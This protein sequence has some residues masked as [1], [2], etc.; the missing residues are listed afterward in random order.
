MFKHIKKPVDLIETTGFLFSILFR[1]VP[2]EPEFLGAFLG[3]CAS[4]LGL[5]CPPK[6]Q[7]AFNP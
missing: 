3:A 6:C 5:V 2:E 7:S 4:T 1:D